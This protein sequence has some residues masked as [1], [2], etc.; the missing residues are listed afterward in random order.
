MAP[1]ISFMEVFKPFL[2]GGTIIGGSKI[3][4]KFAPAQ[5][6][7]LVGGMPTGIIASYFLDTQKEKQ[8]Y[9][10][11][12]AV[13]SV[14]LSL[15]IVGLHYSTVLLPRTNVDILSAVFLLVWACVSFFAVKEFVGKKKK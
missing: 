9:F 15:A 11:G 8:E 5:F 12:Y 2:I 6:A 13:S 1:S 3:V 10:S 7:P 4:A 14:V